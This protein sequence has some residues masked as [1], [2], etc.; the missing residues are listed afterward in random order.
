MIRVLAAVI[1]DGDR[2]LVCLRPAHK[3]HAGH[4]EFPGGKL[5]PGEAILEA[6][7]REL[8]EELGLE[9]LSLGKLLYSSRDPGSSFLI[10]F[11]EVQVSG[12]PQAHEHEEIRWVTRQE[13][14]GLRLAPSDRAFGLTIV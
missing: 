2:Y 8:K 4:W 12:T 10:D 11:F 13:M 6:A 3:R 5:E 14:M 1:R 9:V 7:R